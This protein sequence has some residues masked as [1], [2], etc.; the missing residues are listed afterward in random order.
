MQSGQV[1]L[2][3]SASVVQHSGETSSR[4]KLPNTK[5]TRVGASQEL[6]A[7][8]LSL[9]SWTLCSRQATRTRRA[10]FTPPAVYLRGRVGVKLSTACT[11]PAAVDSVE[12]LEAT[13]TANK[14]TAASG[15]S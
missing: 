9:D 13:A 7:L 15:A 2:F 4:F 10:A 12:H 5:G 6:T 8:A 14:P 1:S 11:L 3:G